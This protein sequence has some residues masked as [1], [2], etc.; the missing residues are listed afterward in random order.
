MLAWKRDEED[1]LNSPTPTIG[2]VGAL[3]L[4]KGEAKKVQHKIS[5]NQYKEDDLVVKV[6]ASDPALTVPGELKLNYETHQFA[7]EYEVKAGA[8]EGTYKVTLAP[9]VGKPVEVL[10]VVK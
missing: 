8:R 6:T 9:A 3:A 5:W 1:K 7:F 2:P 4:S 10:V